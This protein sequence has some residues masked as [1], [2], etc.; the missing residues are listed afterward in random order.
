LGQPQK[1]KAP[2]ELKP[3]LHLMKNIPT[4]KVTT[5]PK[6]P[7]FL[8]LKNTGQDTRLYRKKIRLQQS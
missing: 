4:S 2:A 6:P 5:F 7:N 3:Y 8:L 1:N